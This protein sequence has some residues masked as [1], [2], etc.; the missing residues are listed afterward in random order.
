ME[1]VTV[2]FAL[3]RNDWIDAAS[4]RLKMRFTKAER[5]AVRAAGTAMLAC[6][7]VLFVIRPQTQPL[8]ALL[9]AFGMIFIF[10][11]FPTVELA[12]K[13]H[14]AA[15][16]DSGQ[17]G[18]MAQTVTF[19]EKSVRVN[20][21]RYT[22]E[23]PYE[24]MYAAYADEN[25]IVLSTGLGEIRCIPKRAMDAAGRKQA[26]DLLAGNMKHKF[27]QEGARSWTK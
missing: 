2:S 23:I 24:M 19:L 6:A 15:G 7:C 17:C 9:M 1:P 4:A 11:C 10:L 3:T 20:S 12:A 21:E 27:T 8:P 14:A 13:N 18:V 16:F 25:T 26:E 22:A 5:I